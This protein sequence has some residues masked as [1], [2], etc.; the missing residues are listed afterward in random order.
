MTPWTKRLAIGF[1]ISLAVN[2]MLCG[3][4]LGRGVRRPM[5]RPN[6]TRPGD[7]AAHERGR[8]PW[9]GPWLAHRDALRTRQGAL[10]GARREARDAL[11]S[12]NF[13][14]PSLERALG[15][16]RAETTHAQEEL[17]RSLV[18]AATRATPGERRELARF[19][20]GHSP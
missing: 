5:S 3:F 1:A 12:S 20:D 8:G 9:R 16:V 17:H 14:A 2:L 19:L 10:R 15:A 18:E 6:A 11:L 7:S 4:L 13:D